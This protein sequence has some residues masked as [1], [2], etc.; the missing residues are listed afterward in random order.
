MPDTV[1]VMPDPE[2]CYRALSA[3]DARFDGRFFTGVTSTGIFCRPICP[4]STPKRNNCRFFASAAAAL[5]AGFRPCLRCHPEAAPESFDGLGTG[6][7]LARALRLID[8]GALDTSTVAGL[9]ERLGIGDRHLRRLFR[10]HL[11]ASP[12]EVAQARRILFARHLLAATS[13]PVADVAFESGFR[14][15]RRF[16]EAFRKSCRCSP[17]EMRESGSEAPAG[18]A[19]SLQLAFTPPYHWDGIVAFL[20]PRAIAGVEIVEPDRY[21]RTVRLGA[22]AG[23]IEVW[24]PGAANSLRVR[25]S[26]PG[27]RGLREVARRVSNLFDLHADPA[28]IAAQLADLPIAA[29]LRVPGAWDPFELTVRAILGQQVSVKGASTMAGRI[30]AAYG[31]RLDDTQGEP[32]L[33]FPEPEALA[34]ASFDGI[35]LTGARAATIRRVAVEAA[36]GRLRF[37]DPGACVAQ[38]MATPGIG[39]WTAQY[40]A[41]RALREPDAFPQGDL[42]LR[43]ALSADGAPVSEKQLEDLA[44]QWRP[45][46]AYAAF[47]LW[48]KL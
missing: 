43:K 33:L 41:M 32:S 40:I 21:R 31:T 7:S 45:W 28:A 20:A 35:G 18:G 3:R 1:G 2:I 13:L 16:N 48:S 17:S 9:A 38:L 39:R 10:E 37:D 27:A 19:V 30:A 4:A 14:S 46:R 22:A 11:G 25:L 42:G 12:H 29:G 47:H 34:E 24:R 36:S 5:S 8:E 23:R 6:R 15:L 44:A 26:V